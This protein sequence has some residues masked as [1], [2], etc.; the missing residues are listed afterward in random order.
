MIASKKKTNFIVIQIYALKHVGD[1]N[2]PI[3]K[4]YDYQ[5]EHE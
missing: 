1:V 2:H 3:T 4:D 5:D